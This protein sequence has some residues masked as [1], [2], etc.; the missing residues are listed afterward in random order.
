MPELDTP[1]R[2]FIATPTGRVVGGFAVSSDG[3]VAARYRG[4]LRQ[5]LL[6]CKPDAAGL[7]GTPTAAV[8]L[9]LL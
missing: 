1:R 7:H 5:L 6:A 8:I 2:G 3:Q 9:F 4:T